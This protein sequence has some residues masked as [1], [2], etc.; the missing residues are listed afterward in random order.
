MIDESLVYYIL[1][2]NKTTKGHKNE[3]VIETLTYK[4]CTS[5][6]FLIKDYMRVIF[7]IHNYYV[8]ING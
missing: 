4:S 7:V 2:K 1:L 6:S 8:Q 3:S 5:L